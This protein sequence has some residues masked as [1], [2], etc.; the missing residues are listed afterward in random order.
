MRGHACACPFIR[1]RSCSSIHTDACSN[2]CTHAK[3]CACMRRPACACWHLETTIF[4]ILTPFLLFPYPMEILMFSFHLFC[5]SCLLFW[6]GFLHVDLRHKGLC[7]C[8]RLWALP[9]VASRESFQCHFGLVIGREVV[10]HYPHL[11]YCWDGDDSDSLWF[12][13]DDQPSVWWITH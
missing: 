5:R 13:P 11:P 10:G 4:I 6:E 8:S 12:P 9:H 1:T 3:T 7:V 2:I